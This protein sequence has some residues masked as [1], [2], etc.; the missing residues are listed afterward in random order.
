MKQIS[1][2]VEVTL[3]FSGPPPTPGQPM[4]STGFNDI[5]VGSDDPCF[6]ETPEEYRD[7]SPNE[8]CILCIS[9]RNLPAMDSFLFGGKSDPLIKA[10]VKGFPSVKTSYKEKTLD[11]VWN[12]KLVIPGVTDPSLSV[13]I[14]VEDWDPA[15]NEFMGKTILPLITFEDKRTVTKWYKL[16]NQQGNIDATNRGEIQ[17]KICWR[18]NPDVIIKEKSSNPLGFLKKNDDDSDLDEEGDEPEEN[19]PV[20]DEAE[21]AKLKKEKEE[22]E[23]ALKKELGDIEVK[24]GDYQV[25][26]HIIECRE[27]AAKDL[28]KTSDPIVYIEAFDQKQNTSVKP[29][30]LSCVYDELFI[31]NFR[32]MDKDVFTEGLIKVKVMDA[33]VLLKN[34]L[35]GSYAFDAAQVYFQK[36]HEMYR[37]WVALM[38]DEDSECNGV[39]GYLKL[40][41][42]IIGPGDKLKVHDEE[43][44]MKKERE[45]MAKSGGQD[46]SSQVM[47]PPSIR[48]EWKYIVTTI[49]RA[50]YLPVM[51]QNIRQIGSLIQNG[52]DA[53]CQVEFSGGKPMK[54]KVKTLKGERS[55]MNPIFNTEIWYPVSVPTATQTIK[56]SIWDYDLDGSD[57]I[58]T[59]YSK[60]GVIQKLTNGT[61]PFWVNLYGA[62]VSTGFAMTS[63]VKGGLTKLAHITDD[64][65]YTDL[66]NKYPDKAPSYK[67]RIL[68]SQR[69]E[70]QRPKKYD[71]DEI[72]PFR[73]RVPRLPTQNEPKYQ[74][75]ILK[76]LVVSGTE[77]PKFIDP[78][79]PLKKAKLQVLIG[80]G[81]YEMYSQRVDC[82]NGVC[83][84]A[85][86]LTQ[87]FDYPIDSSQIPDIC[88]Y[89]CKG[90]DNTLQPICYARFKAKD[91]LNE[92]FTSPP[93]WILLQEDKSIDALD[94]GEFPGNLLLRLGFGI[95]DDARQTQNEWESSIQRMKRRTPYQVRCHIYQGKDLPAADSNGLLDP[96]IHVNLLGITHK[97]AE[98]KKTRFPL[99]YQTLIFDCELP[100]RE[101]LP[102]A[103]VQL[104][105]IDLIK[106]EFMGQFFYDLKDAFVLNNPDDPLPDPAYYD[107]FTELPGDGQGSLLISF[108]L[109]PKNRPDEVIGKLPVIQPTLRQAYIE[110]IAIGLRDMKPFNFQSMVAPFL[111]MELECIDKKVIIQT[112]HSKRPSPDDPNFLQRL[113]MPVM[114]PDN[115]LFATPMA[116][117]A[118]DTRL[119][120]FL[121]P[122]VGVGIVDLINKIPW[123]KTYKPPQS[124]IFFQDKLNM[125]AGFI[126]TN[127]NNN[128]GDEETK[129]LELDAAA[130]KAKEL[131]EQ[132]DK[133]AE[134]DF[135]LTQQP[136]ELD[137]LIKQRINELD[138]GA[139]VF[140]ALSHLELPEYGGK[141]KKVAEEY[142]GEIDLTEDEVDEP[143][144]YMIG[145]KVLPYELEEELKTTPFETYYLYRGQK[146]HPV[147]GN[148]LKVVG[149]FKGLVRVML[150]ENEPALFDMTALLK[151]Q[152][153]K[154]RLYVLAGKNLTPM[155][156]GFGGRPGKSDPYL[157][158]KLGKELFDD[159]E[160]AVDDVT[161][162]DIYKLVEFNAEL[163]GYSQLHISVMDKDEI[164]TDDVIGS[165]TIDLEDRWFD[166][167]WQE[168]GRS[169][170]NEDP[171]KLRWDTKDLERRS[172]YV[173]SSN[174]PQG[175]LECWVD[176]LRPGEASA[177]PPDDVA[178]PPKQLFE[179]R[180]VIWKSADVPAQDTL[181]GQN[182]TDL[183]IKCWPE[184]CPEQET[185]THWRSKK[186]KASFNWR[187]LFDIELGHNSRAMKF[188]YFHFQMWDRDIIKW[189]DMIAEG[190]INLGFYYRK[191]FK[192]NVAIKL[193]ETPKG[194]A[195]KRTVKQNKES[196]QV[197]IKD[198][199]ADIPPPEDSAN[200]QSGDSIPTSNEE[201]KHQQ[202]SDDDDDDP[203]IGVLGGLKESERERLTKP[204]T[205]N[206]STDQTDTSFKTKLFN[207][208]KRDNDEDEDEEAE[209]DEEDPEIDQ[210]LEPP[211]DPD[212]E[213][214]DNLINTVKQMTGLWDID[215][216]DST[217]IHMDTLDHETGTREPMGRICYSV[218]IWPKDKAMIM[219]VGTA[220]TEPNQDPYCPPPTGRL[221][222]SWNPFY[223]CMQICGPSLCAKILCCII[224]LGILALMIFCQP[225]LNI[226]I[227]IFLY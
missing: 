19:Q 183:F 146:N 60:F 222:F 192:K 210:K 218:Q 140:G 190:S 177:F 50:E 185:D 34:V 227:A 167:R 1:G 220:R 40:S 142:F 72:E 113:V 25:Q 104:Y 78:S 131:Q 123:S 114:L 178:L 89:L 24:S 63:T 214:Q 8:L 119:G 29:A 107:F 187:M 159:R 160:N 90:K 15:V 215:P 102:Q 127:S 51:D 77:L 48:K 116:L 150:E 99:Y 106:N 148:T 98:K 69:I 86:Y 184:G 22:A 35:I 85:E 173:P 42:S 204:D 164:G 153:Y 196:K 103:N 7:A 6:A 96:L 165:T 32:N 161:D 207:L 171:E 172:L 128:G 3:K 46:I 188:P 11:P 83:D 158:V 5:E 145:R 108:Q 133:A 132:R 126:A 168:I 162:V 163:P 181:G 39:Q 21:A 71:K 136:V 134:D 138:V 68:I 94:K 75:Y 41:V 219:K 70:S 191:A 180:V 33:N 117:R 23:A 76:A 37:Q 118:R 176:I 129:T 224:C 2:E 179:V 73:R 10:K 20:L 82:N 169:N 28:S 13:E 87:E 217:W 112:D 130:K 67:G 120:G 64:I 109:I 49:Y 198:T 14:E 216:D 18:F 157:K 154:V 110:V 92:K 53:Y 100:E 17:L 186:G 45:A 137:Q 4:S 59:T 57:I 88:V 81:K 174:N 105:D 144:K 74:T 38:N 223:M 31:F 156:M 152:Q 135:V 182:M 80:C 79:N 91:L 194:G 211:K 93:K 16:G 155:D 122:E 84:W 65:D 125:S 195:A 139:G 189:N 43:E 226:L 147:L 197:I 206:K 36:D 199:T 200:P 115:A 61:G 95:V 30:C 203:G 9:G 62:F 208:F 166:N 201:R 141:R 66:Y 225:A 202:D 212:Q 44:E 221:Q 124:D 170:R 209:N 175:I 205:T 151:P 193:Y 55:A 54:T 52:T 47:M 213:E 26:V 27:L 149:K 101:F 12:E 58:A 143:P 56:L 97:S 111:E 121:K